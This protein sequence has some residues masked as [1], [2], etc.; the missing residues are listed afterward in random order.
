MQQVC[1]CLFVVSIFCIVLHDIVFFGVQPG[2]LVCENVDQFYTQCSC[3]WEY[4]TLCTGG[5][6]GRGRGKSHWK[7][8]YYPNSLLVCI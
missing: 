8:T 6:R 7:A 1:I 2:T 5:T 4:N 3:V